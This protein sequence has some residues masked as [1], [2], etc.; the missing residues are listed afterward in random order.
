MSAMKR[1]EFRSTASTSSGASSS[2]TAVG[3]T[4]TRR[5]FA[6]SQVCS[7]YT[8]SEPQYAASLRRRP[9]LITTS[10]LASWSNSTPAMLS[11]PA[12]AA[13]GHTQHRFCASWVMSCSVSAAVVCTPSSQPCSSSFS[14]SPVLLSSSSSSRAR[15]STRGSLRCSD[16]APALG[17]GAGACEKERRGGERAQGRGAAGERVGG[18]GQVESK[19]G[20]HRGVGA[21]ACGGRHG[22]ACGHCR[23]APHASL[24]TTSMWC[25]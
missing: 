12:H 9:A 3:S 20:A 19:R 18:R 4:C 5:P 23:L 14:L 2:S 22:G 8:A 17:G 1:R 25:W 10:A 15:R 21:D 16:R 11:S 6:S 24:S 7:T 13:A